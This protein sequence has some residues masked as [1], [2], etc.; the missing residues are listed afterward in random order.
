MSRALPILMYHHVSPAPG[1]VTLSPAIFREQIATLASAGWQSVV[2]AELDA[3]L[4]GEPLPGKRVMLTFDY[5]Y[6]ATI[7]MPIRSCGSSACML[8]SLW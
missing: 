7:C 3:Y 2:T 5:G 1:L 4:G 8:C 6:L